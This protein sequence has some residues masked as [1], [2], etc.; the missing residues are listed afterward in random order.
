[1]GKKPRVSIADRSMSRESRA[2]WSRSEDDRSLA[3]FSPTETDLG[4]NRSGDVF[5]KDLLTKGFHKPAVNTGYD[6]GDADVEENDQMTSDPDTPSTPVN[7]RNPVKPDQQ[8]SQA[9]SKR[10]QPP[11]AV[12]RSLSIDTRSNDGDV[13]SEMNNDTNESQLNSPNSAFDIVTTVTKSTLS[14]VNDQ[15]KSPQQSQSKV[16]RLRVGKPKSSPVI[17]KNKGHQTFEVAPSDAKH[18]QSTPRSTQK[19]KLNAV[20]SANMFELLSVEQ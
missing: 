10:N 15:K 13:D 11:K 6:S 14:K 1:M 2:L 3:H 9:V 12:P 18:N 17:G 16:D 7:R 20:A 19:Q 4:G 5:L 8:N